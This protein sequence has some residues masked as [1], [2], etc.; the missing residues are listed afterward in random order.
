[1]YRF[2]IIA[3]A[4]LLAA[5][6]WGQQA[7]QRPAPEEIIAALQ[8]KA[9]SMQRELDRLYMV[10]ARVASEAAQVVAGSEAREATLIEWLKRA[11]GETK[12]K[13]V[14]KAADP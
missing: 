3:G 4:L 13:P 9:A 6:A 10:G 12:E 5:P 11:Q 1:L 2:L 7:S 14:A 8:E